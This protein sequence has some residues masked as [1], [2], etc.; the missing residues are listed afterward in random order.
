MLSSAARH[1]LVPPSLLLLWN[2]A[3]AL[4]CTMA[5]CCA[6]PVWKNL[7][8]HMLS[9]VLT[10]DIAYTQQEMGDFVLVGETMD[11]NFCIR[12]N[13]IKLHCYKCMK[14]SGANPDGCPV[15]SKELGQSTRLSLWSWCLC[16]LLILYRFPPF[17]WNYTTDIL[18]IPEAAYPSSYWALVQ[19]V[20]ITVLDIMYFTQNSYKVASWTLNT[21]PLCTHRWTGIC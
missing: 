19:C 10:E 14:V 4:H 13:I 9:P 5:P 11:S 15:L 16:L 2:F 3:C 12:L 8:S 1:G 17:C 21:W 18:A 20:L 6:M 7:T